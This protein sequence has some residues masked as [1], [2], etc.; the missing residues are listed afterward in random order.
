MTPEQALQILTQVTG[1]VPLTR[2]DHLTV[3][4]ALNAIADLIRKEPREE[5]K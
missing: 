3:Q 5:G 1:S 4:Q 2:A